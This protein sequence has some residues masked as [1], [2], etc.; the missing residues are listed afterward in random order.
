MSKLNKIYC[1]SKRL[2]QI[3]QSFVCQ[4]IYSNKFWNIIRLFSLPFWPQQARCKSIS[5]RN[6]T[7]L[8][9][10]LNYIYLYHS[11]DW[12]QLVRKCN[13]W[14][15]VDCR[16]GRS[17]GKEERI[18][19]SQVFGFTKWRAQ[20]GALQH[21]QDG[22]LQQTNVLLC[23]AVFLIGRSEAGWKSNSRYR[24]VQTS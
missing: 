12:E 14:A 2:T 17:G 16:Q 10:S 18:H 20:D 13:T 19:K 24:S 23:S 9:N 8:L 4:C 1:I 15:I 3:H 22:A 11:V 5:W 21:A 7:F 6:I